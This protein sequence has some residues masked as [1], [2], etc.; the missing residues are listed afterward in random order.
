VSVL[1]LPPVTFDTQWRL[2]PGASAT[3][4]AELRREHRLRQRRADDAARFVESVDCLAAN[5]MAVQLA[6]PGHALTVLTPHIFRALS[7]VRAWVQCGAGHSRGC[8][9]VS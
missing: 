6:A 1:L 7:R 8:R 9:P 3:L 2:R 4:L 5:L